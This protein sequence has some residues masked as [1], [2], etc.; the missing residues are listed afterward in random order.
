MIF[1]II[2]PMKKGGG[3]PSSKW[4]KLRSIL[5]VVFVVA[6]MAAALSATT[7]VP[8]ASAQGDLNT[9]Y[10]CSNYPDPNIPNDVADRGPICKWRNSAISIR[11]DTTTTEPSL[12]NPIER[13]FFYIARLVDR[14]IMTPAYL[15]TCNALQWIFGSN[16]SPGVDTKLQTMSSSYSSSD[17]K[18]TFDNS[19]AKMCVMTDKN[20]YKLGDATVVTKTLLG[21]GDNAWVKTLFNQMRVILNILL[22]VL[23]LVVAFANIL[24]IQ[25][26]TYAIKK[27]LPAVIVAAVAGNLALP[28][29]AAVSRVV[30]SVQ[31]IAIF[32]PMNLANIYNLVL[33]GSPAGSTTMEIGTGIIT[34][35]F[36]GGS[37][38]FAAVYIWLA[39]C[40]VGFLLLF[41]PAII[42]IIFDLIYAFRPYIIYL[43]AGLSPI[44]IG[45]SVLPATQQWFK[46]WLGILVPWLIMPVLI[47]ALFYMANLLPKFTPS[48]GT[49]AVT[50]LVGFILPIA[51]K[52]G[53]VILAIRL[54]FTL[55]KDIS[56]IIGKVGSWSGNKLWQGVGS[57]GALAY[58]KVQKN[59][60]GAG[61][62]ARA[63]ASGQ[64]G[65]GTREELE[66]NRGNI[67]S[68]RLEAMRKEAAAIGRKNENE[69]TRQEQS[70]FEDSQRAGGLESRAGNEF[71]EMISS[72]DGRDKMARRYVGERG[73]V[74]SETEG[75]KLHNRAMNFYR[76]WNPYGIMESLKLRGEVAESERSKAFGKYSKIGSV[77]RGKAADLKYQGEIIKD[78]ISNLDDFTDLEEY[79]KGY[80]RQAAQR[81]VRMSGSTL[82]PDQ[83]LTIVE[84]ELT[85]LRQK[86][87]GKLEYAA[88]FDGLNSRTVAALMECDYKSRA[89]A[90]R[91]L[92]SARGERTS[93]IDKYRHAYR[94]GQDPNEAIIPD[95][96]AM[97]ARQQRLREAQRGGAGSSGFSLAE[98]KQ[99]QLLS[100]I[101]TALHGRQNGETVLAKIE[102]F[103]TKDLQPS[104][105]AGQRDFL[106]TQLQGSM[107]N[108]GYSEAQAGQLAQAIRSSGGGLNTGAIENMVSR[109][110]SA[111]SS[112]LLPQIKQIQATRVA[113]IA[114]MANAPE[115]QRTFTTAVKLKL[116]ES[117]LQQFGQAAQQMAEHYLNIGP[118][119][120]PE[121]LDQFKSQ[122]SSQLG[123]FDPKLFNEGTAL[124]CMQAAEA[125]GYRKLSSENTQGGGI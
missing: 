42:V 101:S 50:W 67:I 21:E 72:A 53:I 51:V 98:K 19:T 29:I 74:A 31:S 9:A 15:F 13:A 69:R 120:S 65:D 110:F 68:S 58:R 113:E 46:R 17:M 8:Q 84:S 7:F 80:M 124:A 103:D 86:V 102:G 85:R 81:L 2:K 54:P 4:V 5:G 77:A 37:M 28:I 88:S 121:K 11:M 23:L 87:A 123:G 25:L 14:S 26:D 117:S 33:G 27:A 122:L 63:V 70:L 118:T 40:C 32:S 45:L 57:L 106:M 64:L 125:K 76:D 89:L 115:A 44:A 78:D 90:N 18:S 82:T 95:L 91:Q 111:H 109:S 52:V 97:N 116:D 73:D 79:Q 114:T 104:D 59:V 38:V 43:A 6:S 100:E 34:A 96:V 119:L 93:L 1:G 112:E 12:L 61:E 83:A 35:I 92:T 49:G 56:S 107:K 105:L 39:A 20:N 24:H 60:N 62:R 16:Y 47:N 75:R 41:G 36:A 99:L 55:E 108:M 22:V 71:D 30:D 48:E 66:A 3:S 10:D 94:S